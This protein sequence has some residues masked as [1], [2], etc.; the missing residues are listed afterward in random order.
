[1]G[2]V[3]ATKHRYA[4][5]NIVQTFCNWMWAGKGELGSRGRVEMEDQTEFSGNERSQTMNHG[6][7]AEPNVWMNRALNN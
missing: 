3:F 4:T 1:M 7:T 6:G 2:G 5:R